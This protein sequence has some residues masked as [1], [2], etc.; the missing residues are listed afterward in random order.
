MTRF[1]LFVL[2]MFLSLSIGCAH[3]PPITPIVEDCSAEAAATLI[4]DV[5]TALAT[6]DYADRLGALV[7]KFGACVIEKVVTQVAESAGLRAQFDELEAVKGQ[8]ARAWLAGRGIKVSGICPNG[9]SSEE[10]SVQIAF[11]NSSTKLDERDVAYA[12]EACNTQVI[13]AARAWGIAPTPVVFYSTARDLPQKSCR[14][15]DF[16]DS[17]DVEG[18]AAYHD[19]VAGVVYG[20]VGVSNLIDTMI[21]ASHE[22]LEENLDP[23]CNDWRSIGGGRY[24]ALEMCDGVQEGRYGQAATLFTRSRQIMV[25]NYLLP[26]WFEPAATGKFDREGQTR[27]PFQLAP[28]GYMIVRETNG[29]EVNVFARTTPGDLQAELNV[30]R[31]VQKPDARTLRRFR[32]PRAA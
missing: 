4:D 21:A 12:A 24:T 32:Q 28:G 27:A 23:Y 7:G 5:N 15:M 18:A 31:K 11:V 2:A 6:G 10:D 13:E 30:A 9:C 17:L 1:A 26:R 14:I 8:R 16:V 3:T 19:F 25:S 22:C 29:N 20:K